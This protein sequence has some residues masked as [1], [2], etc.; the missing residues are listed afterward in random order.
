M[1]AVHVQKQLPQKLNLKTNRPYNT[2]SQRAAYSTPPSSA[3]DAGEG[4][5]ELSEVFAKKGYTYGD[6]VVTPDNSVSPPAITEEPEDK[7]EQAGLEVNPDYIVLCS[8]LELLYAQRDK[9]KK[10]IVT[11]Y[12]L[13]KKLRQDPGQLSSMIKKGAFPTR[14]RVVKCPIIDFTK[15][16]ADQ[17]EQ[18]QIE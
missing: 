3:W 1:A 18:E 6:A 10:D 7:N 9:V 15:Y 4:Y 11:L 16:G 14:N 17:C 12:R 13:K 5:S 8:T 2:R